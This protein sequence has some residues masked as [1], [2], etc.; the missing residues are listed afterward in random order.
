MKKKG[1]K[2]LLVAGEASGDFLGAELL[3]ELRRGYPDCQFMGVGGEGMRAEGVDGPYNINHLSVIGLVEIVRRLPDLYRVFQYLL[4][5]MDR[6]RP[7]L[8]VTIDLPDFNFILAKRAQARNIPV[9]HYVSPQVWA[10]RRGR[11]KHLEKFIDHLLVL[12]PFEKEIYANTRLPVT[13]VGHPLVH[14][15]LP[16]SMR[17]EGAGGGERVRRGLGIGRDDKWVVILPGSRHSEVSRLFA[18]MI[19]ACFLLKKRMP[20]VCFAVACAPT[21]S[22]GE[23]LR[24]WPQDVG[25]DFR[26]EVPIRVGATYDLVASA[27]AALVTSGT[28]TLETALMGIP[29]VVCYRVN[30][31]TYEIGKWLVR[32]PFFSLV[33]LVAGKEVV[34]ERLQDEANPET[35]CADLMDLLYDEQVRKKMESEYRVVREQLT[36]SAARPFAVVEAMLEKGSETKGVSDKL[37]YISA[38][39]L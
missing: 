16:W 31:L 10:W 3:R 14:R 8:L 15:A 12:F 39:E 26:Q 21:L 22:E 32:I 24:H 38:G 18:P 7:D 29:Q 35:L 4:G 37:N 20:S 28:A 11:A 17:A 19:R 30:R 34:R 5:L 1:W 36:Q 27:D 25:M 33:N 6:Q 9:L 23:L 2:I 13:F